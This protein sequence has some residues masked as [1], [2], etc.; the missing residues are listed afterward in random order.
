MQYSLILEFY[1]HFKCLWPDLG[2]DLWSI[3][4]IEMAFLQCAVRPVPAG[5]PDGLRLLRLCGPE[6]GRGAVHGQVAQRQEGGEA[7]EP[8]GRRGT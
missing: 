5:V 6:R 1:M 2:A 7:E 8:G 4:T 3:D